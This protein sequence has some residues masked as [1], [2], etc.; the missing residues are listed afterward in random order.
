M[1]KASKK[2]LNILKWFLIILCTLIVSFSVVRFV[3]RKINAKVPKGGINQE[4]YVDING[5]KQWISIYGQNKAN[6]VLLYLHGGPGSATSPYDYAFTRK[7]SDIY[8]VVTWDQ[9]N[10][11]K[12]YTP[13]QNSLELT[14][15]IFMQDGLEMTQFILDYLGKEKITL[16]G[17]SWGTLFGANL[18]LAYPEYYD[19]YIGT[20]QVVD[21]EENEKAFVEAAYKWAYGD[22]SSSK[23]LEMLSSGIDSREYLLARQALMKKYGY[24][25]FA[26][27]RD[28]NMVAAIIFNP[29]YSISDIIGAVQYYGTGFAVY[30]RFWSSAEINK[31]SLKDKLE[32]EIPYYNING[33]RDYQA[34]HIQAQEYFDKLKVPVKRIFIMKGETHGLLE[35]HSKEFSDIIHEIAR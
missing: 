13:D 33:D 11:G 24:D 12:S 6:P 30:E 23:Y 18:A 17:H 28:Y 8:T 1:K 10:C 7:W 25:M 3:G 15:D 35:A 32:Y 19:C 16:L 4:L 21:L 5:S 2:I 27:G 26:K 31:F 29:Y 14:H 22:D 34:N 9:R 20:G